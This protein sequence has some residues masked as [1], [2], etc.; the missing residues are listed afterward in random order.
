MVGWIS[1]DHMPLARN[2]SGTVNPRRLNCLRFHW[3]IRQRQALDAARKVLP[4]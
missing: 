3:P 1:A 2:D 4:A